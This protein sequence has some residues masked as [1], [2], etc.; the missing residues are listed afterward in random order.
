MIFIQIL[1]GLLAAWAVVGTV[2]NEGPG[3]MAPFM[4]AAVLALGFLGLLL[5]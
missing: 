3:G 2:S 1:L 5:K 4:T